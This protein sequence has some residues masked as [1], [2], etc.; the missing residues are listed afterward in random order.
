MNLLSST[1]YDP[2]GV[3]GVSKATSALLAMTAFDTTN[4]RLA[5]TVPAHG[6]VRFKMRCAITGATTCPTILLGVLNGATVI[7]RVAPTYENATA[8]AATQNF[9]C[10][11]EF[12]V[13]GLTPGA[14]NVDAAYAVQVV[15]ASTN[16][17]YGGANTNA[18]ANAWGGFLFEAW[19]PQ[20]L[21]LALDG[22]VNVKQLLGTAWLTPA[23]AGTPDV[24]AKQL[25][26][27]AQTG[28]DVGANVLLSTGTG[29]GQLDFT[30]GVVKANLVQILGT[31]ITETAGQIA[32][33]FKQ[34][35]DVASP[36]GTMK[37]ITAVGTLTTYTGNTPQTGDA[38][39]RLGAPA[40][41]SVSADVAAAKADTAAIK[42]SQVLATGTATAGA[43]GSI[44]LQNALGA[45]SLP[46]GCII[47]I[48][49]GTGIGQARVITGYVN[50]TRVAT[51]GHNWT[52]N[53][54]ATSVYYIV[55]DDA[56][57]VDSSLK[58]AGV[59][60][61]D[62][63]T[64]YTGNTPQTGDVFA[65]VGAPAGASVSADVASIK[66]DTGTTIPGR[67]PAALVSGR[68]DA[69]VGAMAA[70]VLTATAINADAI[71]DA[72]VASDV[73][74]ASVT[75]AVASVTGNVGGNVTGSVGSVATGGI[76]AGSIAASALNGKGD[77]N[78]GK[79]GYALSA[80]GVQ[81]IW[82]AL[83]SALTTVG[84]IGKKLA[85]WSIGT[86]QTGDAYARLGA[87]SGA[88]VS[89][90]VAA[91]KSDSAAIKLK[92]DNLPSDPA[93]AS[94][95]VASFSTVNSS[96]STIAGYIDTEVAAI[97]A[98]TDNLPLAPA[99]T[100]DCITAAGVRS[101]VG[102]A[103]ANLDTQLD[104]LPTNAE[105]AT[106]LGTADDAV[107]AAVA[108]LNNLSPAD[109][110]IAIGLASANLD[111]Q[112]GA[113]DDYLDTEIAAIKSK[114]D[115]LPASPA[116]VSD[117]PTADITSIK[118]KTD[119]LAFTVANKVDANV[120]SVNDVTVTG[121]GAAGDEWGP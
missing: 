90:D 57:K 86:A 120:R 103:S 51:V 108:A 33:A 41:A 12:T 42:A 20:P 49:G 2:S 75:G 22:G 99:A 28:R 114:T 38:Y 25:G 94:D 53:P 17:K 96:L 16:I 71:T 63:V 98:K 58:V 14:M 84:S 11:A 81:A 31:A 92:T 45:D 77:W 104:A 88:S 107:L 36:T 113:I 39:A 87:P 79:T 74:I 29:A 56:A 72:K 117:I 37:A 78:I 70:N 62:T 19:D 8:N 95:I 66:T 61:T 47:A 3:G 60:L 93:D 4:L 64:T 34:F 85:D 35:F 68:M 119:S 54:D 109:V 112:L 89:A 118:A 40:G 18:G 27:T 21:T 46:N 48:T 111:S 55:F 10:D 100:S 59:V 52:T 110:R 26:G 102:M 32:A 50:S 82:D 91:I 24:N 116:A 105:L 6:K 13:T 65:R 1:L 76:V 121:T 15:V 44:T 43:A 9:V 80:A 69:S 97:K 115:N 73:T 7:G 101:A 5:I 106:A 83:T 30:S 23:V 67:L